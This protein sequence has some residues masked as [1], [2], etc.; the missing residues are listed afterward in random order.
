MKHLL[1]NPTIGGCQK[2]PGSASFPASVFETRP[3]FTGATLQ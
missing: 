3:F 2:A 1:I